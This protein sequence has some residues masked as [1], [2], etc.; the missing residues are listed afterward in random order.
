MVEVPPEIK[1]VIDQQ[2][3]SL[4]RIAMWIIGL[5]REKRAAAID[6]ARKVFEETF[7]QARSIRS[8]RGSGL[9]STSSG[10]TR[11]CSTWKPVAGVGT[12]DAMTERAGIKKPEGRACASPPLTFSAAATAAGTKSLLARRDAGSGFVTRPT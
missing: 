6:L 1:N 2:E 12:L 11:F 10:Y 8:W 5:P 9:I 7:Q 3:A 4:Q